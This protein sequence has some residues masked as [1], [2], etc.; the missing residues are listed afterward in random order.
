M[1]HALRALAPSVLALSLLAAAVPASAFE[2]ELEAYRQTV[3]GICRTGVTAEITRLY[4]EA[5][6][7]VDLARAASRVPANF[8][9]PRPPEVAYLDCFQGR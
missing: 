5:V 1:E 7:A 2:A 8:A 6:K 3:R 9:G 4:G